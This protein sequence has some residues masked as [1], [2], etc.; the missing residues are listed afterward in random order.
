MADAPS[1]RLYLVRH[2][3]VRNADGV[4]YGHLDDFPL[5]DKGV[6]QAHAIGRHLAESGVRRIITSPL[7]RARQTADIVA[8]HLEGARVDVSDDLIEARFGRYLQGVRPRDVPWRRPLWFIHMAWPGLLPIDES[9][10][11]MAARIRRQLVRLLR[12]QPGEPGMC[13]SH[14]DPIQAFWVE[15]TG[16]RAY[17]LHRLQCAKGGMLELDYEGTRLATLAYRSPQTIA[18]PDAVSTAAAAGHG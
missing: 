18:A 9:V 3:D 17:A 11:Q 10:S 15:S 12:E 2:C 13:I 1:T 8:S 7:E 14:G 5:S 16:R 6:Q 4:L